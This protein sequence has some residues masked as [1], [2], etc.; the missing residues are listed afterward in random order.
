MTDVRA[1]LMPEQKL[2]AIKQLKEKYGRLPWLET[3]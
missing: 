3:E 2:T 1:G